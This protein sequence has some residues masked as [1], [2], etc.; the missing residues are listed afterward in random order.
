M[1]AV[2]SLLIFNSPKLDKPHYGLVPAI[3]GT[4]HVRSPPSVGSLQ[5]FLLPPP[6]VVPNPPAFPPF[7]KTYEVNPESLLPGVIENLTA[8]AH[9]WCIDNT[10]PTSTTVDVLGMLQTTT[11][12]IRA[13]RNYV[14]SLPDESAGTI[15]SQ[16]R[17]KI[18]GPGKSIN[19]PSSSSPDPLTLIRKCALG[20]PLQIL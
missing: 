12:A 19:L 14:L 7:V 2:F 6:P 5:E 3:G 8:V 16:F 15:R 11:R 17:S 10:T 4:S 9:A 13:V 20:L 18:L 1:V